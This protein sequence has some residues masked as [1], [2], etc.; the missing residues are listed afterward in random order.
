MLLLKA[1]WCKIEMK[2][3]WIFSRVGNFTS[4]GIDEHRK[5]LSRI[6][7]APQFFIFFF[8]GKFLR[9]GQVLMILVAD[10]GSRA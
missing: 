10:L 1:F 3:L 2:L 5:L 6:N 7:N 8:L 4:F 9:P